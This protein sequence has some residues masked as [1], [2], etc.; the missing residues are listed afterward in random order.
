M[1]E[2]YLSFDI[3]DERTG[4]IAEILGNKTCKKILNLIA[5]KEMS[6]GD[7]AKEL[8]LA[9]NTIEYNLKKLIEAGLIE[10]TSN[11]F[12]STRGKKIVLYKVANKKIIIS[13]KSKA[14]GI[15]ASI[16]TGGFILGGLKIFV[17]YLASET[18][19]SSSF[20]NSLV[21]K[22]YNIAE[23]APAVVSSANPGATGVINSGNLI[24]SNTSNQI[25][26]LQG[27]W[28]WVLIGLI[29]G[30]IG[31]FTYRKIMKGGKN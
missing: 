4:K 10:K 8:N 17:N 31:F 6:E 22:T 15:L 12:C 28:I 20:Q 2:K 3:N 21:Q 30:L 23:S 27:V 9:L 16:L 29:L 11:F 24:L 18:V 26:I 1:T 5:E 25:N 14:K 13:P 19:Y 7:I